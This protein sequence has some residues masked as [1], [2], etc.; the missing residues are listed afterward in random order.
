MGDLCGVAGDYRLINPLVLTV[1]WPGPIRL[2]G[3]LGE[4]AC[5]QVN[6]PGLHAKIAAGVIGTIVI[7]STAYFAWDYRFYRKQ[8]H[9]E[10]RESAMDAPDCLE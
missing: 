3:R 4:R 10:A 6:F 1:T 7:L 9:E 2:A 8:L 5:A